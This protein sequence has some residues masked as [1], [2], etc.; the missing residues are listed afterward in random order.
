MQPQRLA[1]CKALLVCIVVLSGC[2]S[3]SAYKIGIGRLT[4]AEERA[5]PV[6]RDPRS[7]RRNYGIYAGKADITGP[8]ADVELMV[9]LCLTLRNGASNAGSE[10]TCTVLSRAMQAQLK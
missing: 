2:S 9:C 7:D 8:A 5:G 3:T 6:E 4:C 10:L 1:F